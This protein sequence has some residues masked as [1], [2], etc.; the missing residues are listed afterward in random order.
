MIISTGKGRAGKINITTDGGATFA[1]S[2][3]VW[4]SSGLSDG[5]DVT[6]EELDEL[7]LASDTALA[8]DSALKYLTNRAHAEKELFNKL[9]MKYSVEA[10]SRAVEKCRAAGLTDDE[11]FAS[12][13]AEELYSHKNYA[14]SRIKAELENRGIDKITAENAVL[15][16]DIDR[17]SGIIKILDKM[18]IT[19]ESGEKD[20]M[21]AVRRLLAAGYS[22][23]EIR[24]HLPS[25]FSEEL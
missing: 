8:Y 9:K 18:K 4:Y 12:L 17:D 11:K 7:R 20:R 25:G 5:D 3:F 21:R 24:R 19:A 16:L 13:Y 14:P 10:A 22:M 23:G 2:A 1:V 6:E 15:A